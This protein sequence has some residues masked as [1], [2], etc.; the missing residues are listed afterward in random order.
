MRPI[1]LMITAALLY[2]PTLLQAACVDQ[3]DGSH[4][5]SGD[6][7]NHGNTLNRVILDNAS[8]PA[9]ILNE[10]SDPYSVATISYT[11]SSAAAAAALTGNGSNSMVV[12]NIGS[13]IIL[14]GSG[15]NFSA[16]GWSTDS[17]GLLYNDGVLAGYAAAISAG[18]GVGSLLVNNSGVA[19]GVLYPDL[20]QVG[21][22]SRLEAYGSF[23]A[24]ILANNSLLTVNNKGFMGDIVSF[25]GATYIPPS[26]QDGNQYA[27]DV[28]AGTTIIDN[29]LLNDMGS[30]MG[31]IYVVDRNPLLDAAKEQDPGLVIAYSPDD[32][33]PRNSIISNTNNG[34]IN[35]IYLGSG[36]HVVNNVGGTIYGS[37][38][39]DQ[40]DSE[41]IDVA[42][43]T[44]STLYKVHGERDFTFNYDP[45]MGGSLYGSVNINDVV[46]ATNT[47]NV[48]FAS[49]HFMNTFIANGL[50][51]NHFNFTCNTPP[52]GLNLYPCTLAATIQGFSDMHLQ[53]TSI[54]IAGNYAVSG[55]ITL[56]AQFNYLYSIS[57]LTAN[58]VIVSPGAILS[59]EGNETSFNQGIGNIVGNLVNQGDVNVGDAT[60]NV[61]GNVLMNPGSSFTLAVGP[62]NTGAILSGGVTTFS[63]D[64]TLNTLVKPGSYVMNGESHLVAT[65]VNGLPVINSGTGFVQ[66]VTDVSTGDLILTARV[67]V[68]DFFSDEVS[69]AGIN[70]ANALFSSPSRSTS[71]VN[72]F[73][74]LQTLSGEDVVRAAERLRPEINDGAI[75][76]VMNSNDRIFGV[77]DNRL[78]DTYLVNLPQ[79]KIGNPDTST[80]GGLWVQGFGD[81]G[82]QDKYQGVDGYNA[83]SAGMA[84][85][86][87]KEIDAAGNLRVG[88]AFG[89]ARSNASNTGHTVNNRIDIDSYMVASYMSNNWDDWYLNA[90]VGVG[91]NVYNTRR[92]LLQHAA[93]GSHDGWQLGARVSVGRPWLA[94]KQLAFIPT[95]SLDYQYIKESGY[96]EQGKTSVVANPYVNGVPEFALI[97]SPIN[98]RVDG[99]DFN[100][101]RVGLGGKMI[102]AI[103]QPEWSAELEL[104]AMA[105]HEFG[106]LAQDNWARFTSGGEGFHSPG[107]RPA[108]DSLQFGGSLRVYGTDERDQITLQTSY[109]ADIREKYFGQI[110]SLNLRYD[111]NQGA[112]YT[113]LAAQRRA[114]AAKEIPVQYVKASEA[115]IAAMQQAMQSAIDLGETQS[116]EDAKS[117]EAIN[118][119]VHRWAAALGN[120]N[121]DA[122]FSSYAAEFNAPGGITRQQWERKRLAEISKENSNIKI[123]QLRIRPQG[124][125]AIVLFLQT[126]TMQ[127]HDEVVQKVV[128]FQERNG[129][130]LI[131][132]EDTIALAE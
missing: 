116:P 60:L 132:R 44:A 118:A 35:N 119:A 1:P 63:P 67:G 13:S 8:A 16:G 73:K 22:P 113:K 114:D 50:G 96:E 53:G 108:R 123:S 74:Q 59:A 100:S 98:L 62:N 2:F 90:I 61:S 24:A 70:A 54:A 46:G 71:S 72:L 109:D 80:S 15:R 82:E 121:T 117:Q 52:I 85:G 125:E 21:L 26:V 33:G 105:R 7:E 84:A 111:F 65:N 130:W 95:A 57:T 38:Y 31:N 41:I 47:I 81:R 40:R 78:L 51:E 49:G 102:Y 69:Q 5:C 68:P 12:N 79:D 42:G 86:V 36:L 55:D 106:D 110:V 131:V 104:R 29:Q 10:T 43:G 115:E 94:S 87:D 127:G 88:F 93:N 75:R 128:D 129:R 76:L 9:S 112:R 14:D 91:R 4:L 103:E 28:I 77:I 25:A 120:K 124:K 66:W 39:V 99:R 32:V 20:F 107:I 83:S 126:Q 19:N 30:Y 23:T 56:S 3:G 27:S 48:E 122:Y 11:T 58:N 6:S 89:Y 45:S 18:S 17:A 37:I 64:S 97:D 34:S 101:V 92:Q